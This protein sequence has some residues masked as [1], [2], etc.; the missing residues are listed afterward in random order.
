VIVKVK[1]G[2]SKV[3]GTCFFL[4][5]TSLLIYYQIRS[6]DESSKRIKHFQGILAVKH[7]KTLI[8]KITGGA[9]KSSSCPCDKNIPDTIIN[10]ESTDQLPYWCNSYESNLRGPGQR[11][12][13]YTLYGNIT[14]AVV[15]KKY[16]SLLN[17]IATTAHDLYPG[18]I[19]RIYHNLDENQKEI[20][21][22]YC[23]HDNVELCSVPKI[24]EGLNKTIKSDIDPKLVSGL[25]PKMYRYLP[26]LDPNV[27]VFISRDVDSPI[28]SRE[29]A[30]VKQWL[31]SNYTFH[32]MRDHQY[33]DVLMLAGITQ[34]YYFF[35]IF[36]AYL[37]CIIEVYKPRYV[38]SQIVSE[39]GFGAESY[40]K[41]SYPRSG[42]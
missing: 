33:H 17:E 41:C 28:W 2:M 10:H 36:T 40:Q 25:N 26:M 6:V 14:D 22:A 11:V 13:S 3:I 16:F 9:Y 21:D 20:C 31:E 39:E 37:I 34:S 19:I 1:Y 5:M 27:D 23:N 38:W 7:L 35:L 24:V 8:R 18:W 30:A 32:L 12:I 4:L 42:P 15:F 29:V